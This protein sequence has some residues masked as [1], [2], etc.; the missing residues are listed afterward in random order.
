MVFGH[1]ALGAANMWNDDTTLTG[2]E[3]VIRCGPPCTRG[4]HDF[5]RLL[6]L[7]CLFSNLRSCQPQACPYALPTTLYRHRSEQKQNTYGMD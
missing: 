5:R 4:F 3:I 6:V 1:A 2:F 7:Y